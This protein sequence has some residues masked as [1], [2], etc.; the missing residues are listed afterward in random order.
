MTLCSLL[1]RPLY[2]TRSIGEDDR[3]AEWHLRAA[4]GVVRQP[5]PLEKR[6]VFN[7]LFAPARY[8]VRSNRRLS[9][10]GLLLPELFAIADRPPAGPAY[11]RA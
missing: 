4:S 1:L 9:A 10:G 11:L 3:N 7:H 6:E 8:L 5:S 2:Y